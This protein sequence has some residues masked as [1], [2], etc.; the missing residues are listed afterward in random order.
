MTEDRFILL[1]VAYERRAGRTP[2]LEYVAPEL[3]D[4]GLTV[5]EDNHH[6][7]NPSIRWAGLVDGP[8][9]DRFADAWHLPDANDGPA[10]SHA[11]GQPAMHAHTLDGMN[12]ETRGDSPIVFATVQVWVL[13]NGHEAEARAHH[14]LP[15]THAG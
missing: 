1:T 5:I 15:F 6:G 8:T 2:T 12:W 4:A 14:P 10:S 13:G 3:K 9:F 7:W 11:A